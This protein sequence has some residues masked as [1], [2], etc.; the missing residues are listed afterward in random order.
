MATA[1]PAS[2]NACAVAAPI[3]CPPPVTAATFPFR[4]NLSSTMFEPPGWKFSGGK[5][6]GP[7]GRGQ[8]MTSRV[9]AREAPTGDRQFDPPEP[10]SA[11]PLRP[12]RHDS[13]LPREAG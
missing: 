5:L 4:E 7:R 6:A 9:V 3:P 8:D 11:A 12:R 10:S 2:P 1:A 13:R